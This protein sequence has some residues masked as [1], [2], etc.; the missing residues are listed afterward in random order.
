LDAG[1]GNDI[2]EWQATNG[3]GTVTLGAG[4]DQFVYIKG[5]VEITDFGRTEDKIIWTEEIKNSD[6]TFNHNDVTNGLVGNSSIAPNYSAGDNYSKMDQ[7]KLDNVTTSD[8]SSFANLGTASNPVDVL[9]D[10]S[11]SANM[12]VVGSAGNDYVNFKDLTGGAAA[13]TY[14]LY[15]DIKANSGFD[16][17][18]IGDTANVENLVIKAQAAGGIVI[19][20]D[21]F[22]SSTTTSS[23]TD[24][25]AS[26]TTLTDTSALVNAIG[27]LSSSLTAGTD[28]LV[29]LTGTNVKVAGDATKAD[30]VLVYVHASKDYNNG[31]LLSTQDVTPIGVIVDQT[32]SV[33][34]STNGILADTN[35]GTFA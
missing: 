22:D 8:W 15:Y 2:V 26:L 19:G 24:T 23:I 9:L 16:T 17:L 4:A 31:D 30:T 20:D 12:N 25:N 11:A 33:V 35:F 21:S 10:N 34:D 32:D 13:G 29:V 7:I 28:Y 14:K 5:N 27:K 6:F 18:Y 3:G 1:D